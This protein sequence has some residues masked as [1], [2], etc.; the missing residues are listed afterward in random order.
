MSSPGAETDTSWIPGQRRTRPSS[1]RSEA[2]EV[3]RD[4]GASS[5]FGTFGK[6][7]R[8]SS[9]LIGAGS[10]SPDGGDFYFR[11]Q[12][13]KN[14]FEVG[15]ECTQG[16]GKRARPENMN[17]GPNVGPGSYD[18][19]RS[20]A[21][22]LMKSPIDGI[23][24]CG[25]TIKGRLKSMLVPN[26]MA[27]PGPHAKY[28]VRK[29]LVHKNFRTSKER[30]S[31]GSRHR[32]RED[33]DQPGPG[34]YDHFYGSV[35]HSTSCPN[36]RGA[37]GNTQVQGLEH[38][39]SGGTKKFTGCTFG[40]AERF[41]DKKTTCTPERERYYHHAKLLTS[42]DYLSMSKTCS[43]GASGKTDFANPYK[44]APE[45]RLFK[46]HP[47]T[48]SPNCSS[49]KP[50][51]MIDGFASRCASPVALHSRMASPGST[52]RRGKPGANKCMPHGA[53]GKSMG[54]STMNLGSAIASIGEGGGGGNGGGD[55]SHEGS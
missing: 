20:A 1:I 17:V 30:L 4:S 6:A 55:A 52:R 43:F 46:V 5:G 10:Q 40:G 16:I 11:N 26:N 19:V 29:D 27:S 25:T 15:K 54:E 37:A 8:F 47:A 32:F 24:Y 3:G 49:I 7:D 44:L 28:D 53:G 38:V 51:S 45:H 42:E 2:V 41:P 21:G 50:T 14:S 12:M 23:E 13:N 31:H 9:K 22:G 34:E 36:F 18:I 48:Y 39:G 33:L 35:A